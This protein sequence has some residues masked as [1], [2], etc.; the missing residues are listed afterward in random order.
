MDEHLALGSGETVTFKHPFSDINL[1][2]LGYFMLASG[3]P[4]VAQAACGT[5]LH[6]FLE[7]A[8]TL[9]SPGDSAALASSLRFALNAASATSGRRADLA[10]SCP[11]PTSSKAL[12]TSCSRRPKRSEIN[13]S[14][15]GHHR[16]E[17]SLPR[18]Q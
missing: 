14:E 12:Q 11:P 10:G 17:P 16:G 4:I 13:G 1:N 15:R 18:V 5:E 9:T 2:D 3:K 8:A 6:T 7:E